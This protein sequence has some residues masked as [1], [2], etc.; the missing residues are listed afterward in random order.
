MGVSELF[1]LVHYLQFSFYASLLMPALFLAIGGLVGLAN[2]DGWSQLSYRLTLATAIILGACA[3]LPING[4]A[5]RMVN[6]WG[7][8]LLVASGGMLILVC[9]DGLQRFAPPLGVGL[10]MLGNVLVG[11][12]YD[13]FL[14]ACPLERH[15]DDGQ[16]YVGT[17][18][19]YIPGRTYSN[20]HVG[21]TRRGAFCIACDA[22][23]LIVRHDPSARNP[24]ATCVWLWYP[25]QDRYGSV[26]SAISS[27]YMW[28]R[29]MFSMDFPHMTDDAKKLLLQGSVRHLAILGAST[30]PLFPEARRV[31]RSLGHDLTMV[32]E[33]DF[34]Q[35]YGVPIRLLI[36]DVGAYANTTQE[37]PLL[38]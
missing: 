20:D 24:R 11:S 38:P 17:W 36:V 31:V 8:P 12:N 26:F 14:A 10:V 22:F 7:L 37:K 21:V 30:R 6:V 18:E 9:A 32:T 34:C 27:T 5:L 28:D 16:K 3:L 2:P 29:R 23:R 13:R 35:T 33:C 15:R 25:V 4:N 1:H 19:D